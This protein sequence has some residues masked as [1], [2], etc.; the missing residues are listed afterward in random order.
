MLP[1][2]AAR[3]GGQTTALAIVVGGFALLVDGA[4]RRT[5]APATLLT[6]WWRAALGTSAR[7]IA[8][9]AF[10]DAGKVV[11]FAATAAP[12]LGIAL[13]KPLLGVAAVPLVVL[14]PVASRLIAL[15]VDVLFSRDRRGPGAF[16]RVV[17]TSA[18]TVLVVLASLSAGA[19][20]GASAALA[21][22]TTLIVAYVVAAAAFCEWRLSAAI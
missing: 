10:A 12:A 1:F 5:T 15:S 4:L 6:P 17:V 22:A 14:T 9:W 2:A 8:V 7:S 11:A 16:V 21:A 19:R 20:A 13:G 18:L 3:A